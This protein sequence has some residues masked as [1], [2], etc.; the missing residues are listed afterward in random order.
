MEVEHIQRAKIGVPILQIG[1]KQRRRNQVATPRWILRPSGQA[2][3][4]NLRTQPTVVSAGLR[5]F[6]P[7]LYNCEPASHI[8]TGYASR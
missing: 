6:A 2:D 8:I 3:V 1:P 4:L 7:L 5:I